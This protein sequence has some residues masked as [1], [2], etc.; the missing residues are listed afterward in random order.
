MF[1]LCSRDKRN[2]KPDSAETPSRA[3]VRHDRSAAA[4]RSARLDMAER[5]AML[6]NAAK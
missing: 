5:E 4:R 2:P 6:A 1:Y 3:R